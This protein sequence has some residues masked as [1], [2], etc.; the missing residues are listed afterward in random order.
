[1]LSP[2]IETERLILRRFKE[3]DIDMQYEII[4]DKRL[5]TYIKF[6]QLTKEEEL[7]YIRICIANADKDKCEKW[8]ITL[9][10][11]NTPIGNISVNEINNKNNYCT[12]GYVVLFD[13]WGKGYTTEATIAVSDYL[14]KERNYYLVE[15]SCNE[16]NKGSSRVL[17]KAGFKK[18][19]YIANRR[20]NLDGTY[21][22]VDYYSKQLDN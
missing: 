11:N 20:I 5:A 16:N 21:S 13:Y 15:A 4:T 18:D 7:E 8:V 1:M 17:L 22:G 3:S 12:I 19:G 9:K 14:L 6:P 10:E 2:I